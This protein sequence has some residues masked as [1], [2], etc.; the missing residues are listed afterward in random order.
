VCFSGRLLDIQWE[1]RLGFEWINKLMSNKLLDR[2]DVGLM[3]GQELFSFYENDSKRSQFIDPT[4]IAQLM[5]IRLG[6]DQ[7]K[8]YTLKDFET[9][10]KEYIPAFIKD[11]IHIT[12][13]VC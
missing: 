4:S 6:Y 13:N 12:R 3:I 2:E 7:I 1:N 11:T 10:A 9:L 8:D 5:S